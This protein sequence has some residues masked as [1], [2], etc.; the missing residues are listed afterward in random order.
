M[1]VA[2]YPKEYATAEGMAQLAINPIGIYEAECIDGD[3]VVFTDELPESVDAGCI[4]VVI[5]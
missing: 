5:N 2:I 3:K 4:A 1:K